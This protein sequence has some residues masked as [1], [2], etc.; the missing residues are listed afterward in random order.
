MTRSRDKFKINLLQ[1]AIDFIENKKNASKKKDDHV[2]ISNKAD[3]EKLLEFIDDKI[4]TKIQNEVDDR[5]NF[6][7][8]KVLSLARLD[9]SSDV[10]QPNTG[11]DSIDALFTGLNMLEEELQYS[12]VSKN[13][14]EL[15][16]NNFPGAISRVNSKGQYTYLND[17]YA[18]WLCFSPKKTIGKTH[19]EVL[20]KET[21][22]KI[23]KN[24]KAALAGKSLCYETETVISG[25]KKNSC[26][27]QSRAKH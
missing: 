3:L 7:L 10:L 26:S 5:V 20:P 8:E 15:V 4:H 25:D 13:E 22:E 11:N 27:C 2:L 6:A 1:E 14:L 18:E 21:Y 16:T 9:F 12:V 19:K 24:I 17:A 23:E